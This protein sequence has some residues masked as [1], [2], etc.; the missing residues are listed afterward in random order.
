[1]TADVKADKDSDVEAAQKGEADMLW[2]IMKTWTGREEKLIREIHRSV[3]PGMYLEC[4]MIGQERIWRKQQHNVLH[5]EPLLP[6]CVF[7]TCRETEPLFRRLELI[8]AISRLLASGEMNMLP[9]M[10]EDAEF[11]ERISGADHIVRLSHVEKQPD[12][13]ITG[14]NGP[15]E[16]FRG[17]VE[18]YQFKKRYALARHSFL[19]EDISFSLG[20]LLDEDLEQRMIYEGLGVSAEEPVRA[21]G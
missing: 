1:M 2:Y 15:L 18:R 14:I 9:L 19:G 8:P 7:I 10:K 20:I 12:G 5:I 3:S 13:T 6:G 4:F 17:S 21:I 11:L 16:L